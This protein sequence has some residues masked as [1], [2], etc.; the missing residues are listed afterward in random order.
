MSNFHYTLCYVLIKQW[1]LTPISFLIWMI[2]F[3]FILIHTTGFIPN[4][5]TIFF[6]AN[7][8]YCKKGRSTEKEDETFEL[9]DWIIDLIHQFANKLRMFQLHQLSILTDCRKNHGFAESAKKTPHID[10]KWIF[11]VC[12]RVCAQTKCATTDDIQSQ[13][14][15]KAATKDFKIE[16]LSQ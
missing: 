9:N 10:Q 7:T 8:K 13:T 3:I 11:V 2:S 16:L 1:N 14:L 5:T 4:T 15:E 12:L 6:I